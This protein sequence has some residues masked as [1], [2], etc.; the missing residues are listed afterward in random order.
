[1]STQIAV[2]I[3][4]EHLDRIDA[5]VAAGRY[6]SRA[7]AVRAGIEQLVREERDREIAERYRRGYAEH[8]QEEWVGRAGL[9][10]G[11]EAVRREGAGPGSRR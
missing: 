8:P 6:E 10:A 7:A 3:P 9:A 5:A 2:R 11:A 4:D 1:M